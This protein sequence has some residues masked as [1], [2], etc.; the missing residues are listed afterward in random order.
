VGKDTGYAGEGNGRIRVFWSE[1]YISHGGKNMELKIV[2]IGN[3]G[4]DP[5]MR[6]TSDGTPVASF[7]MAT[8]R[9]WTGADG[10]RKTAT[11]WLRVSVWRGL[12][13]TVNQYLKKG[14]LV[15]VEGYLNAD[16]ETGGP[17]VFTRNDGS[18]GASYE[19][20]ARDVLFLDTPGGGDQGGDDEAPPAEVDEDTIPF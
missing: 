9:R 5:E 4:R 11:T 2:A 6:Y 13:E 19:V 10:E 17:R 3:L 15:K 14:R 16:P 20:T 12:A 8:N 7:S 1:E 18:A